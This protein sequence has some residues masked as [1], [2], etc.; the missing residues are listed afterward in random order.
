LK[1]QNPE[2]IFPGLKK[3]VVPENNKEAGDEYKLLFKQFLSELTKLAHKDLNTELWFEHFDNLVMRFTSA[4][5]AARVKNVIPDV[6]LYDHLATTSAI[7]A[8]IYL[9]HETNG[10]LDEASVKNRSE[11]KFLVI[12]GDF[13]GIQNYIFSGFGDTRKYRSKLLRGRSFSVSLLSELA[14]DMLCK[15]IGLPHSSV[16]L[17]AGGRFSILAPNTE[18]SVNA[19]NK[20]KEIVNKWLIERTYGETCISLSMVSAACRDF[21]T[22]AFPAGRDSTNNGFSALWERVIHAMDETKFSKIDLEKYGGAVKNYLDGFCNDLTPSI[23]PLCGKRAAKRDCKQDDFNIC[24]MCRDHIFLGENLVKENK[25]V[26]AKSGMQIKGR[27]LLDPVFGEYQLFFPK[28]EPDDFKDAGQIVKYWSIGS[29]LFSENLDDADKIVTA[30]YI[31]G[32][33]PVY[34]EADLYEE[35]EHKK[36]DEDQEKKEPGTPKTF[37]DIALMARVSDGASETKKGVEALAVLKADVDNLGLLMA[38]GLRENL[39]TISRLATLS[40]QMNNYFAVYLPYFLESNFKFNDIYTVF[41]GG[42]DL[43]LLGPWNRITELAAELEKSFKTYVCKNSDIHFSAGITLHKP[44]TPVDV[45]AN[46]C[47]SALET[48]KNGGRNSITLFNQTV[49]WTEFYELK[50]VSDELDNWLQEGWISSV[51]LYKINDFINMA[52]EERV[53][54]EENQTE[55]HL[56]D[57]ACTKWRSLLKYSVERNVALKAARA[58]RDEKVKYVGSKIAEWLDIYRA[59]LRIPLWIIQYNRR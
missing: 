21:E 26:I 32:Y 8:A 58:V 15:K 2:S 41:A 54:L 18:K 43:F 39:Y 55:I 25:V 48:S 9:F 29:N 12:S 7:A 49:K 33:V 4:I 13:N 46:A 16:I 37:N 57:M 22:N 30:K 19:V 31:N 36:K 51:F 50:K 11:E 34:S 44:H 56:D 1:A 24:A 52:E 17:N 10:T 42:D 28:E 38:C 53:I 40:R 59:K 5:P 14:A 3:D 35:N 6:S 47:E 45:F 20:V 27:K 23:C